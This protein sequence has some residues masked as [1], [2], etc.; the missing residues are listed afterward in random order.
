MNDGIVFSVPGSA[1]RLS[2]KNMVSLSVYKNA[3]ICPIS[4]LLN[5][6]LFLNK[7]SVVGLFTVLL[8]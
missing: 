5:A 3:V 8:R 6:N 2:F 4:K 1:K 7:L